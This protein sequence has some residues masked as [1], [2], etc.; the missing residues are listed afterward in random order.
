[1]WYVMSA[2][3]SSSIVVKVT[4][5][6]KYLVKQHTYTHCARNRWWLVLVMVTNKEDYTRIC[7]DRDSTLLL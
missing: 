2:L 3:I 7:E 4:R 6:T 1:M 5:D